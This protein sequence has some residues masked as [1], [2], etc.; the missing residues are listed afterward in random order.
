MSVGG[1]VILLNLLFWLYYGDILMQLE[2]LLFNVLS[3]TFVF[4]FKQAGAVPSSGEA[5]VS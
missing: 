1:G 3:S 4:T 5:W 2:N